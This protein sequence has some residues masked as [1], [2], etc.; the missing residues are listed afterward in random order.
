MK[1]EKRG[2]HPP[3]LREVMMFALFGITILIMVIFIASIALSN[4]LP[5]L[6]DA[7]YRTLYNQVSGK[8]SRFSTEFTLASRAARQSADD[9]EHVYQSIAERAGNAA[10]TQDRLD[11]ML[12]H[13]LGETRMFLETS[14]ATGAFVILNESYTGRGNASVYLRDSTPG[15]NQAEGHDLTLLRGPTRLTN[16]QGIALEKSWSYEQLELNAETQ[17]FIA[18]PQQAARDFPDLDSRDWGYW[19]RPFRLTQDDVVIITFTTPI[20]G[21]G[22]DPIGVFGVEFSL[23]YLVQEMPS[24][25]LPF[26]SGFYMMGMLEEGGA[27]RQTLFSADF[28]GNLFLLDHATDVQMTRHSATSHYTTYAIEGN[29]GY[30]CSRTP[31]QIYGQMSPF[32]GNQYYLFAVAPQDELLANSRTITFGVGL[33]MVLAAT[34]ALISALFISRSISGRIESLAA[35][36]RAMDPERPIELPPTRIR[37][38]DDLAHVLQEMSV[39]VRRYAARMSTIVD[40][41]GIPMGAFEMQLAH[42]RV[43]LTESLFHLLDTGHG[44]A[45]SHYMSIQNFKRLLPDIH[46]P[47]RE[48]YHMEDEFEWRREERAPE[49]YL[50]VR[51]LRRGDTVYG[52]L[53]DI[54][55]EVRQKRWLEYERDYDP[56]TRLLNRN[57]YPRRMNALIDGAPEATGVMLFADL[58]NL[59]SVNDT[60]GH[61]MGDRYIQMAAE[62]L[63]LFEQIGGVVARIS[64]DE[65]AAYLH[66]YDS[67]ETL[68]ALVDGTLEKVRSVQMT[69][70]DKTVQKVRMSV[71][72]AYYPDDAT[73]LEALIH[74]ADFAMYEIKHSI[75]G[76]TREF[77]AESYE[78]NSFILR[79]P[80]QLDR[81][82]DEQRLKFAFQPILDVETGEIAAYEALMRP[83][84]RE[85]HTPT[86][87]ITLARNQSKLYQIER[88]TLMCV[89]EW[90]SENREKVQGKKIFINLIAGQVLEDEEWQAI[91]REYPVDGV[92][93]VMEITE[94]DQVDEGGLERKVDFIRRTGSEVALDDYGTGYNGEH[95][96]LSINPDFLK[97]DMSIIRHIDSDVNRQKL[98]RQIVDYAHGNGIKVIAEGVETETELETVIALGARYIQGFY[99]G[100][101]DF[102]LDR[103]IQSACDTA[104]TLYRE[105]E[106]GEDGGK[107]A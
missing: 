90:I 86:E 83:Q 68:R 106:I 67:R 58:D 55:E 16:A 93:I 10:Y 13:A 64:G 85:F 41:V 17:G 12:Y 75:K 56:L 6:D 72:L 70:P 27:D 62:A 96:L 95:A 39:D 14:S 29:P 76:G 26:D 34:A 89:F 52:T 40:L 57:S 20:L 54:S 19:S 9:L 94:S 4:I 87:V 73:R 11:V 1:K 97:I 24:G 21:P 69:L 88:L 59:K 3:S 66:G 51:L 105:R 100:P 77:N 42:G 45:D 65:F 103:H 28:E 36:V 33:S 46:L 5:R 22:G 79:K 31:L 82:I 53:M 78:K 50:R 25:D 61:D 60:Y 92:D 99:I 104:Q 18:L 81:L 101:P 43:Y 23:G 35:Q 2:K 47:E 38:I 8:A 7:A 74:Y 15:V 37:E 102:E 48:N 91:M 107:Q 63:R 49:R 80:T 44:A 84:F 32:L 98:F 71:G 30:Y